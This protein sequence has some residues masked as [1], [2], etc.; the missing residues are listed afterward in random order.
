MQEFV[1]HF[2]TKIVFGSGKLAAAG[3][4][5]KALGRRPLLLTTRSAMQKSGAL[6]R[7]QSALEGQGVSPVLF[8][9]VEPNPRIETLDQAAALALKERCDFVIALGGGSVMDG[10]KALAAALAD[11]QGG[12]APSTWEYTDGNAG[13]TRPVGKPLPLMC[14][15]TTAATGSEGNCAAVLTKWATHEKA[16]LWNTHSFPSVTI[17]DPELH[18][19][20]SLQAT[21]DGVLDMIVHTLE[22]TFSGDDKAYYQDRCAEG[23]VLGMMEGLDAVERNLQDLTARENLAWAAVAALIAGGGPNFGRSGNWLVHPLEH[24]VSGHTDCSHGHGLA[25]LWPHVMR[26]ISPRRE[27]KLARFGE[28][29]LGIPKGESSAEKAITA[30]EHWLK[31]HDLAFKLSQ[32]GATAPMCRAMA[33]DAVRISGGGR[34]VIAGPV[35]IDAKRAEQIYL[36]AL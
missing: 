23:M 19:S 4:E 28:A 33:E 14:V 12:K 27:A 16:V 36:A 29:C 22:Q 6:K 13:G 5:A 15:S 8:E 31:A 21:R 17:L 9:G 7:L 2:P 3:V 30:L 18:L 34:G 10:S 20:L 32:F 24:P 35:A 25:A 11:A 1:L 26:T